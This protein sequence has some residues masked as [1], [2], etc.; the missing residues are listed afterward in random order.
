MPENAFDLDTPPDDDFERNGRDEPIIVMPDGSRQTYSRASTFSNY[1]EDKSGIAKWEKAHAMLGVAKSDS[2]ID[3]LRPM[4][5]DGNSKLLGE[6]AKEAELLANLHAKADYGTAVHS[7]LDPRT[8]AGL[9]PWQPG[10]RADVEA[11]KQF[12]EH[13]GVEIHSTEVRV[14]NDKIRAA[15]T[16]DGIWTWPGLGCTSIDIKTGRFSPL[17]WTVQQA[18]YQAAEQYD[19]RV[20]RGAIPADQ[21]RTPITP[22]PRGDVAVIVWVPRGER[23]AR[24][25]PVDLHLGRFLVGE[26]LR[27]RRLR[28]Q[29]FQKRLVLDW[30]PGEVRDEEF[31]ASDDDLAQFT[32][33]AQLENFIARARVRWRELPAV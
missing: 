17:S 28:S 14:V 22:Y 11:A 3:R 23:F 33:R 26:A 32:S 4:E 2:L 29:E 19:I 25:V 10:M 5:Y 8:N 18:I 7:Y 9:I 31:S 13:C 24:A 12:M 20:N 21:A 16:Y 6:L 1:L 27:V 15:G 30:T